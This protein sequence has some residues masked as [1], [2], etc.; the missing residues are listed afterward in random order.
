MSPSLTPKKIMA[1][2]VRLDDHSMAAT[3]ELSIVTKF[4]ATNSSKADK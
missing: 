1:S 2:A 4:S 3:N